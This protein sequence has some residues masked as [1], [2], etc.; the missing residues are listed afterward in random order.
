MSKIQR[1]EGKKVVQPA[2]TALDLQLLNMQ[3]VHNRLHHTAMQKQAYLLLLSSELV[4][5]SD[6]T[7][8]DDHNLMHDCAYLTTVSA[9]DREEKTQATLMHIID[10]EK[11]AV[12]VFGLPI[13]DTQQ[14]IYR[15]D[16]QIQDE[17]FRFQRNEAKRTAYEAEAKQW[18]GKLAN[19][20][21]R[22]AEGVS[23][24][25]QS[26]SDQ[27]LLLTHFQR[28]DEA[29]RVLVTEKARA[30]SLLALEYELELKLGTLY[31]RV[32]QKG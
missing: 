8:E 9:L 19:L 15:V 16:R 13:S 21:K 25:L 7:S 5:T 3:K 24:L 12:K 22:R 18:A 10:R 29:R 26:Y 23:H 31:H 1:I 17:T 32:Q 27:Q 20:R 2:L 30:Q 6:T 14:K 4:R 11:E 28:E